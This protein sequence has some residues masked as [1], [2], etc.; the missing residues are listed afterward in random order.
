MVRDGLCLDR[1]LDR[2]FFFFSLSPSPFLSGVDCSTAALIARK[3]RRRKKRKKPQKS[4]GKRDKNKTTFFR[5]IGKTEGRRG[6]EMD[7]KRPRR[8][9]E[10][11]N[12]REGVRRSL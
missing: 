9:K 1:R 12:Q 11:R 4:K 7:L 10:E 5:I 8:R 6:L 2:R 3:E